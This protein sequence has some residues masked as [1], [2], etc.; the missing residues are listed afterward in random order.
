MVTTRAARRED[1]DA[2][3]GVHVATWRSAYVGLLPQG[4][5]DG[6][7]AEGS[8]ARW[9]RL[10][11]CSPPLVCLVA[12]DRTDRPTGFAFAGPHRDDAEPGTAE[13]YSLYVHPDHSGAG[14]GTALLE[15]TRDLLR[16][17][18]FTRARLW[19]LTTNHHARDF[20]ERRGWTADVGTRVETRDGAEL[21]ETR[22]TVDLASPRT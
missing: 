10:L 20:Y 15:Q 19:V 17:A 6:L 9:R 7:S 5:L 21:H 22:L 8:A 1:A 11:P 12:V 13:L 16:A 18:G 3:G 2:L 4:L 14:A